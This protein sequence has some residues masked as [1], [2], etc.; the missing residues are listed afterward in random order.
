M[1]PR[2]TNQAVESVHLVVRI[3]RRGGTA[4]ICKTD[5]HVGDHWAVGVG[6]IGFSWQRG[7]SNEWITTRMCHRRRTRPVTDRFVSR[8]SGH[9]TAKGKADGKH[10]F[11]WK[12]EIRNNL[13]IAITTVSLTVKSASPTR[14]EWVYLRK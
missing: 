7:C 14:S 5:L 1:S 12:L 4:G 8:F 2:G 13:A 10:S 9:K 3:L 11:D 6:R